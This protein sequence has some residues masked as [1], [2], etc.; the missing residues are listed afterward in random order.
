MTLLL[1]HIR[2]EKILEIENV[3]RAFVVYG[4]KAPYPKRLKVIHDGKSS[5]YQADLYKYKWRSGL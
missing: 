2:T 1:K 4:S 5:M 3:E